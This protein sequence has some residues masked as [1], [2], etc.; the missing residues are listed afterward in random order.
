MSPGL[1]KLPIARGKVKSD[2]GCTADFSEKHEIKLPL[3]FAIILEVSAGGPQVALFWVRELRNKI[4]SKF[5]AL[6]VNGL[7]AVAQ[8]KYKTR[9]LL[10]PTRCVGRKV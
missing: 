6:Q 2:Q 10:V 7:H 9:S 8:L 4:G 5:E 3:V 1:V